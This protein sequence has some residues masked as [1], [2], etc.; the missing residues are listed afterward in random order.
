MLFMC[1]FHYYIL[2]VCNFIFG[3]H[4]SPELFALSFRGDFGL[5]LLSSL[6]LGTAKGLGTLEMD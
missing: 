6:G 1:L 3:F 5:G 4:R 2:E